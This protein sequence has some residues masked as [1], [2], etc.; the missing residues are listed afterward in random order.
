MEKVITTV[1]PHAKDTAMA[2]KIGTQ[3][4]DILVESDRKESKEM[5][6]AILVSIRENERATTIKKGTKIT[7]IILMEK[8]MR[9]TEKGI[10][11]LAE[12]R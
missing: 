4:R 6:K 1:H 8:G 2:R 10:T 7:M 12:S 11:N 5:E 3:M 9:T